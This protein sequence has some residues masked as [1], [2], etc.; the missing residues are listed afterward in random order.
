MTLFN[1]TMCGPFVHAFKC[2]RSMCNELMSESRDQYNHFT[3]ISI[4][5]HL[6]LFVDLNENKSCAICGHIKNSFV[7]GFKMHTRWYTSTGSAMIVMQMHIILKKS[8]WI[9]WKVQIRWRI[10]QKISNNILKCV[11]SRILRTW[12]NDAAC[13][14]Q[15]GAWFKYSKFGQNQFKRFTIKCQLCFENFY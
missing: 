8:W 4:Q 11:F 6:P 2:Y 14:N 3:Q 7:P 15:N 12:T 10:G 13:R 5:I 9:G 1:I